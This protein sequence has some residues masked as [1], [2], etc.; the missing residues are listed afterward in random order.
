MHKYNVNESLD[1]LG[2]FRTNKDQ[3]LGSVIARAAFL[4]SQGAHLQAPP[5]NKA[6]EGD[7]ATKSE[8]QAQD[9]AERR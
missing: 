7:T 8:R 9:E 2:N 1:S 5:A 6:T 3:T 4:I